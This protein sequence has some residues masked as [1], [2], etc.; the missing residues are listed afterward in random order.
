MITT[1]ICTTI[2]G[3]LVATS[4][5]TGGAV[6]TQELIDRGT[7]AGHIQNLTSDLKLCQADLAYE[8]GFTRGRFTQAAAAATVD[9]CDVTEGTVLTVKVSPDGRNFTLT[10]SSEAAPNY[11]VVADS[12][13][14]GGANVVSKEV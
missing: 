8:A 4:L 13:A 12:S 3:V 14:G 7:E 2:V 11:D 5:A 10:A 6:L 9:R 1:P